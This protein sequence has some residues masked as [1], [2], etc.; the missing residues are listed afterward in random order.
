MEPNTNEIQKS[1]KKGLIA[2]LTVIVVLIAGAFGISKLNTKNDSATNTV[3]N[4]TDTSATSNIPNTT[5]PDTTATNPNT[6]TGGVT[7]SPSSYKDGTYS[8]VGNYSSP[9][10]AESLSVT[11]TLKNDIVT[12]AQVTAEATQ[13]ESKRYQDRFIGGFKQFVVGKNISQVSVGKVSGSSLTPKGFNDAV[14]QIKV[15]AKS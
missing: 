1:N 12:D 5:N 10:G 3:P 11:L 15:Q 8:A 4:T 14:S 9:G 2:G 7:A 6:T 13:P